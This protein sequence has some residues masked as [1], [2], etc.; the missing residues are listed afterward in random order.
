MT[1]I[2]ETG[3]GL[4]DAESYIS[5]A[6]AD[7]YHA[8]RGNAAWAALATDAKE[9]ALR[10]ATDYMRQ[11]YRLRWIGMHV[12]ITQALDWPRAWVPIVDSP[13]GYQGFPTYL[14][15]DVVPTEVKSACAELALR[16]SS[17]ALTP[18][19][20]PQVTREQ[21]GPISVDYLPG[22]RQNL[23]FG[24]VEAMLAPWL[25]GRGAAAVVRA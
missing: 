7:T 1:L 25:K 6:D 20:G 21:V 2:V 5:V 4:P 15:L 12:S 8:N 17:A 22:G 18:D 3:A 10:S 24:A 9:Q 19:V 23:H 14:A 13:G 11:N 16:A